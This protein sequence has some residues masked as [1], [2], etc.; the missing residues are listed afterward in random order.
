MLGVL[1]AVAVSIA[2]AA[3]SAQ[4]LYQRGLVQEHANGDLKQAIALYVQAAKMAG[5]DRALAAKALV[6]MAGAPTRS[7][8]RTRKRRR[9][10]PSCCAPIRSSERRSLSRRSG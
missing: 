1:L 4:E 9:R 5:T 3:Q 7:S 6:R 8:G 10:M 2:V